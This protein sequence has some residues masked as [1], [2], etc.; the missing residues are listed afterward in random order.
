[1]RVPRPVLLQA[2]RVSLE[3]LPMVATI[4]AAAVVDQNRGINVPLS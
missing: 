4:T 2:L 1:M 3:A